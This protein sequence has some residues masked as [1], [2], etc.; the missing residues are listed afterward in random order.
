[1]S[2][3][4]LVAQRIEPG[5]TERLREWLAELR[6]RRDEA[7]E[8]LED[9]GVY[10]ETAFIESRAD[11]DYLLTYMEAADLE[12]ALEAYE[13]SS[14]EIDREHRAVLD[15][16]LADEEPERVVEPAYHLAT[17]DRP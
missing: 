1:M 7:I 4:V 11:G 3:V 2:D 14:H 5:E 8:T 10:A 6:S 13:S 17:P 16:V 12:R 9:E 15:E